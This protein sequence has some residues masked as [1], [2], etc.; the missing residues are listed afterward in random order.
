MSDQSNPSRLAVLWAS[1]DPEVAKNVCFM[2]THNAKRNGWFDQVQLIVWGPSAQL[3]CDSE[4]LQDAI[5]QMKD[6]GVQVT[7]C[8]ACAKNYGLVE[9][10]WELGI[11]V[12]GMGQPL[13]AMLK[14]GWHVL[15]F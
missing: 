13:S 7:A 14:D 12:K 15:T 5:H 3:L 9:R 4:P 2:Y 6:D 10:L 1:G 11:E 8:I